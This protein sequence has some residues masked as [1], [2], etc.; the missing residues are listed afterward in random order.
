MVNTR[1]SKQFSRDKVNNHCRAHY[2]KEPLAVCR[3]LALFLCK[4]VYWAQRLIHI[5]LH[6]FCSCYHEEMRL[7]SSSKVTAV[8]TQDICRHVSLCFVE[9]KIYIY[10]ETT[11]LFYLQA[12]F[13]AI[14]IMHCLFQVRLHFLN[15]LRSWQ[16]P[17]WHQNLCFYKSV[18]TGSKASSPTR[19]RAEGLLRGTVF[20]H[21]LNRD[22]PVDGPETQ[23]T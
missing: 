6:D 7:S 9:K 22:I 17:I 11:S 20:P 12:K 8:T 23:N 10:R 19:A 1:F 15:S 2:L 3:L 13:R 21:S 16:L 5:D 4:H 18:L 14:A